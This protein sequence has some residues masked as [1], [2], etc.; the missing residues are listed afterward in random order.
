M[1]SAKALASRFERLFGQSPRVFRAP[2]RVNLIGEHTDYNDG[3]VMPVAIPLATRVAIAPA[4]GS[5][6]TVHSENSAE[7]VSFDLN[8]ADPRPRGHWSDYVRGVAVMLKRAIF[9][10]GGDLHGA[11][12]LIAGDVPLGSG[13][14]SSAALE[15]AVA[16]SLLADS[17]KR[18]GKTEIAQLCQRAENEFVGARCG[19]MDQFASCQ[20]RAN[21]AILLDCRSVT[22]RYLAL[23]E[24]LALVVAN[25]M[26]KHEHSAGEYNRRRE[27]CEQGVRALSR[28]LPAIRALRDVT[29]DDLAQFGAA[30]DPRILR[31]CRH[32]VTENARA[33]EAAAALGRKD[34]VGFGR[35]MYESHRSLRDDYEVSCAE[36]DVMVDL[37]SKIDGVYGSR[38]TGGG[39]GGCTVS[40]VEAAQAEAIAVKIPESY[41]FRAVEGAGEERV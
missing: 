12:M 27:E 9:G 16:N 35:L 19:I 5:G 2:G 36:L 28:F 41:V 4:P 14:S 3:F 37:A 26:V 39:F 20:G 25:T 22:A 10:M 15:V 13:L 17:A 8:D 24:N 34:A 33:L 1:D 38:M 23:P 18:M 11:N 31:R 6:I 32:V 30:L 40:L 29:L 21:H 7:T